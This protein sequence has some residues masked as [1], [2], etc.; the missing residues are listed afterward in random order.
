LV[1]KTFFHISVSSGNDDQALAKEEMNF[2]AVHNID[3]WGV[4]SVSVKISFAEKIDVD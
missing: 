4:E 1:S 2:E 3:E